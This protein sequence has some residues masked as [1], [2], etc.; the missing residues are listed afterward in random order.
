M[1]GKEIIS[2]STEKRKKK[3]FTE[4]LIRVRY[5]TE[6][7]VKIKVFFF[8]NGTGVCKEGALPLDSYLQ[9]INI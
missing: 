5:Q 3:R 7:W 4:V 1:A 9:R 8:F 6:N 2:R